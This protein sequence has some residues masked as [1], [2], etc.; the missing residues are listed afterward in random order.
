[1]F[2]LDVS[3]MLVVCA[4]ALVVV[5]PKDLPRVLRAAG[6]ALAKAQ[7]LRN[8]VQKAVTRF[9]DEADLG[10]IDKEFAA[11]ANSARVNFALDPAMTM[12]GRLPSGSGGETA[13]HKEENGT[14]QYT[15]PAMAAYLAAPSEPTPLAQVDG[16]HA[17][18]ASRESRTGSLPHTPSGGDADRSA[19]I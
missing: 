4:V 10:S 7:R 6:Q 19:L 1:M 2:D 12:R 15:S 8:D 17:V 3:K 5:G 13:S 16:P 9:A 11:V 18:P 14:T